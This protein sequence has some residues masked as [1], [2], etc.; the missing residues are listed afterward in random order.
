MFNP[1][2]NTAEG[3]DFSGETR[4]LAGFLVCGKPREPR[5]GDQRRLIA[6]LSL[7]NF[8]TCDF[9]LNQ[10]DPLSRTMP[11]SQNSENVE[12]AVTGFFY[13]VNN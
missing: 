11:C 8:F 10:I 1:V 4:H 3:G 7:G 5:C 13:S 6:D 12:T 9:W 2:S